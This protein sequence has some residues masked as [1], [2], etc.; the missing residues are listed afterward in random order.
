MKLTKEQL[1]KQL[2]KIQVQESKGFADK[3]YP[4]FQQFIGK[5]F[6]YRNSFSADKKWWLYI[7]VTDIK[8]SSVYAIHDGSPSCRYNGFSFQVDWYGNIS[9]EKEKSGYFHSLG[10]EISQVEFTREF[11]KVKA[12]IGKLK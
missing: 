11:N 7:K 3:H 6:K 4:A 1:Q 12:K 10:K 8:K 5:C 9:I 2:E